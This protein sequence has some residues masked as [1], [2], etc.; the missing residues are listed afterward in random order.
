MDCINFSWAVAFAL[1]HVDELTLLTHTVHHAA[2][3]QGPSATLPTEWNKT[4]KASKCHPPIT[5]TALPRYWPHVQHVVL[6]N[7][8][9]KGKQWP[10]YPTRDGTLFQFHNCK[11]ANQRLEH[12]IHWHFIHL[13]PAAWEVHQRQH[14]QCSFHSCNVKPGC[15]RNIQNIHVLSLLLHWASE[16]FWVH[17]PIHIHLIPFSM[18]M[19][20]SPRWSNS[21][22]KTFPCLSDSCYKAEFPNASNNLLVSL[23]SAKL[24]GSSLCPGEPVLPHNSKSR[25]LA[26]K[27]TTVK[28][29]LLLC[30]DKSTGTQRRGNRAGRWRALTGKTRPSTALWCCKMDSDELMWVLKH[31][32]GRTSSFSWQHSS[33]PSLQL[34]ALLSTRTMASTGRKAL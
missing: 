33:H 14:I 29:R 22:F 24:E 16:N 5:A 11:R 21:R 25:E 4:P 18:Q 31:P 27:T 34:R 8:D 30:L 1:P 6:G 19:A 10:L 7:R 23:P 28:M 2:H 17:F 32:G 15:T 9:R 3:S 20:Q 12:F 13:T 26:S